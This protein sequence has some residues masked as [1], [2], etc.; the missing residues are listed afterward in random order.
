ME[1]ITK[2]KAIE[3]EVRMRVTGEVLPHLV[4]IGIGSTQFARLA[5]NR[6]CFG[7]NEPFQGVCEFIENGSKSRSEIHTTTSGLI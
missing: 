4:A 5:I 2:A 7:G 1:P 6:H 3:T